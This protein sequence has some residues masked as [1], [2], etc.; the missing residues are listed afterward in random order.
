[1]EARDD[2]DTHSSFHNP[3]DF[4]V[5]SLKRSSKEFSEVQTENPKH[6]VGMEIGLGNPSRCILILF[7]PYSRGPH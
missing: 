4:V 2:L 5:I 1:M 6:T 3:Q 7:L